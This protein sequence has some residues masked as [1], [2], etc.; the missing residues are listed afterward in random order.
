MHAGCAMEVEKE[1]EPLPE[2]TVRNNLQTFDVRA[3]DPAIGQLPDCINAWR[4]EAWKLHKGRSWDFYRAYDHVLVRYL[5]TGNPWPLLDLILRLRRIPGRRAAKFLAAITDGH[6]LLDGLSKISD[7]P[8][9]EFRGRF[10]HCKTQYEIRICERRGAGR[11]GP[12]DPTKSETRWRLFAGFSGGADGK[13]PPNAFWI[14]FVNALFP[15]RYVR[16]K[17]KP[18]PFKAKLVRTDGYIGRP[19]NPELEAR[20]EVLGALVA[21][22]IEDGV[23]YKNA[24]D[25]VRREIEAQARAERALGKVAIGVVGS[26]TIRAAYD[27]LSRRASKR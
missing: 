13:R 5:S 1:E 7:L 27:R 16:W 8:L 17:G 25:Q 6:P 18:F 22:K 26:G 9:T 23:P 19:S 21:R 10:R 14:D 3:A 15:E 11:L 24:V 12:D 4:L 2:G 20:D